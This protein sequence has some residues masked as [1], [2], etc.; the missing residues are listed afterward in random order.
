MRSRIEQEIDLHSFQLSSVCLSG[1]GKVLVSGSSTGATQLFNF[2]L[3]LP[4]QWREWR[5][6]GDKVNFMK[7]SHTNDT[8]VTG[9]KN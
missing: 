4:G 7:I 9:Q 6:H 5:I 3:A 8:L 2:P 1:E